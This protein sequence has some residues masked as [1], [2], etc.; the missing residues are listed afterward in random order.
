[1]RRSLRRY[2]PEEIVK[3]RGKGTPAEATLRAMAREWPRLCSQLRNSR[4][5]ARGYVDE[6]ALAAV[7][8]RPFLGHDLGTVSV[9]RLVHLECWLRNV[10]IYA[11]VRKH[12]AKTAAAPS[13]STARREKVG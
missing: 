9:V 12:V 11:T 7:I 4:I 5:V 13:G 8:D 3:R 10:E 2:L 1:M 6:K